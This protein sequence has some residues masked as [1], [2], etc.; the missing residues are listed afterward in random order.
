MGSTWSCIFLKEKLTSRRRV[1]ASTIKI[2][3]EEI[4]LNLK[5]CNC[6]QI[7]V[8][9]LI[10]ATILKVLHI[11]KYSSEWIIDPKGVREMQNLTKLST[12]H[13]KVHWCSKR[14][15]TINPPPRSLW[16]TRTKEQEKG[17]IYSKPSLCLINSP[18]EREALGLLRS[19]VIL[20]WFC[21][22]VRF[23]LYPHHR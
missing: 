6:L 16:P 12:C 20:T 1:K 8:F 3:K 13:W 14:T 22:V 5:S 21:L 18:A 10:M 23:E 19:D 2:K 11:G 17:W 9:H 7:Q 15:E 4:L